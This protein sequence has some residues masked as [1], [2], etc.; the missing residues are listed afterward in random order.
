MSVFSDDDLKRMK[1]KKLPDTQPYEPVDIVSWELKA[2]LARLE[3]AEALVNLYA[4][5]HHPFRGK[6]KDEK[7]CFDCMTYHAWRKAAGKN[8]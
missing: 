6:V 7:H 3:A 8:D 4:P 1:D 5:R 2:L